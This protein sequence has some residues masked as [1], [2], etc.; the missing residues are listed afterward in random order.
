MTW[1]ASGTTTP[2]MARTLTQSVQRSPLMSNTP[3]VRPARAITPYAGRTRHSAATA[4][5]SVVT[6]A[7]QS[8]PG[9]TCRSC[10]THRIRPC[11]P[12]QLGVTG[13]PRAAYR[14]AHACADSARAAI[15]AGSAG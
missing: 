5:G 3:K 8:A 12:V 6:S 10:P 13:H 2:A 1:R 11:I 14:M 9:D 7:R 4:A 15:S